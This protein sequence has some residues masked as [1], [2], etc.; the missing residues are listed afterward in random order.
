MCVRHQREDDQDLPP[1]VPQTTDAQDASS[2]HVQPAAHQRAVRRLPRS[3]GRFVCRWCGLQSVTNTEFPT[4]DS[5]SSDIRQSSQIQ[6]LNLL[7]LSSRLTKNVRE[8][9]TNTWPV[10][11]YRSHKVLRKVRL[12]FWLTAGIELKRRLAS[13]EEALTTRDRVQFSLK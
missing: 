6:E 4:N 10:T 7:Q 13:T 3:T 12:H 2:H 5:L 1:S 8:R 11:T 9:R